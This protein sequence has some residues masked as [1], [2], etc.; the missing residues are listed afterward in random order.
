M[1]FIKKKNPKKVARSRDPIYLGNG[2]SGSNL[3]ENRPPITPAETYKKGVKFCKN[4]TVLETFQIFLENQLFSERSEPF[5][6]YKTFGEPIK[7]NK[8]FSERSEPLFE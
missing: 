1:S 5:T 2:H 6:H 4:L 8:T 3:Y 7:T